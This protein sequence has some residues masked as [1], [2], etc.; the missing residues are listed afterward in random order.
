[1]SVHNGATAP[2]TRWLNGARYPSSIWAC[3]ELLL[4]LAIIAAGLKLQSLLFIFG[5]T[6]WLV[7]VATL[8]LWWRG[9]GWRAIGVRRPTSLTRTLALGVIA[10]LATS[11]W[12]LFSSSL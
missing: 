10:E 7:A 4:G 2:R 8:F 11:S 12:A 6:P 1:M 5:S 9:P 3:V